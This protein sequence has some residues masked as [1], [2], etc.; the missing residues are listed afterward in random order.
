M[1]QYISFFRM[2]FITGL[3]Y[4]A[5]ALGGIVTQFAWGILQILLFRAFYMTNPSAFPMGFQET[6]SYIWLQQAFLA[7]FFVWFIDSDI[8]TAITSGGIAYE[9]VRPINIYNMWFVKNMASRLSRAVLRCLPILVFAAFL[10]KPYGLSVPKNIYLLIW[11]LFSMVLAFIVVIAFIM[12]IY[13]VTF[14]IMNPSGIRLI[15]A[16]LVEFLAGGV[17][18]LP[19]FPDKLEK[20][21]S[22]L[23]FASMQNVPFRIYSGNISG[24]E[25]HVSV[26][27]QVFWSVVLILLGKHM[28]NDAVKKVRVQGG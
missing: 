16:S 7:L 21:I 13:I 3:Q 28:M 1:H 26:L 20:V 5:A 9:L 11:F 27:L 25:L 6:S 17:I 4:R 14:Y 8:I 24:S 10:K 2:R 19:F 23:P 22:L 18:P 15:T 12:L